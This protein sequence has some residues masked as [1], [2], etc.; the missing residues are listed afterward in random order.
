MTTQIMTIKNKP[1]PR[2]VLLLWLAGLSAV[3]LVISNLM[4]GKLWNFFGIPVDGGIL[5]FPLTYVLGDVLMEFYGRKIADQVAL[6]SLVANLIALVVIFLVLALPPHAEWPYQAAFATAFSLTPRII[7]GS[8]SAYLASQLLNN[9]IFE[10]IKQV[11][12]ERKILFRTIGSSLLARLVDL[13]IF[14]TIAFAGVLSLSAFCRQLIFAYF[15]GFC[16]EI[17]LSP[18]TV[19]TIKTVKKIFPHA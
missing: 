10:K 17:L 12:G 2:M 11:T 8:L 16:L 7:L 6:M 5:I 14:E 13:V 19:Y 9:F 3:S 18:L 1:N 4:A 15:A